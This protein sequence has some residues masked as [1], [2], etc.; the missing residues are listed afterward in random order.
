MSEID[1]SA[2]IVWDY[3]HVNQQL[4]KADAILAL[5]SNDIRV[6]K[7]AAQLYLEGWAPLVVFSGGVGALTA[8]MWNKPEAEVFADEAVKLGVPREKILIESRSANTGENVQFTKELL[9][10]KCIHPNSFILVQKPYMERRTFATFKKVWPEK[11]F[12][13]T[14]PQI[15]FENYPTAT[16]PKDLI[17]DIMVGDLER[18]KKYP[19]RGFQIEQDIPAEV[20]TAFEK[21]VSAGYTQ[22]LIKD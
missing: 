7:R 18:I 21:L 19:A 8:G 10:E 11:E 20:W 12:T 9:H 14:S 17:I 16:L 3:H 6:A 1:E 2:K 13:V 22:H 5:G 15:S 4:K